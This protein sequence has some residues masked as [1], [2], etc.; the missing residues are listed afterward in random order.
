[1]TDKELEQ[2]KSNVKMLTDG[3]YPPLGTIK[4]CFQI[5]EEIIMFRSVL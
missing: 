4:N 3:T 5:V 1:M 2:T